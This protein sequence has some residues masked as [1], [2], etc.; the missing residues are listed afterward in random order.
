[1]DK[2]PRFTDVRLKLIQRSRIGDIPVRQF[3]L[4]MQFEQDARRVVPEA[5]ATVSGRKS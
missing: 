3:E 5:D 4:N 1:L 2:S